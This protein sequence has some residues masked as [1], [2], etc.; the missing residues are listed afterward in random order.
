DGLVVVLVG[1]ERGRLEY[2]VRRLSDLDPRGV[3][4]DADEAGA[5]LPG[6]GDGLVED[7]AGLSRLDPDQHRT[8]RDGTVPAL[9]ARA[10]H[11]PS[12]SAG[13]RRRPLGAGRETL[14]RGTS[15]VPRTS[16][17]VVRV[18]PSPRDARMSGRSSATH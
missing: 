12:W 14:G 8:V 1:V 13:V 15:A 18:A 5:Q 4:P 16:V 6:E 3:G 7:P 11:R 10:A 9:R 17:T 2:P